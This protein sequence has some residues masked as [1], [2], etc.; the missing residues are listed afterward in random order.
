MQKRWIIREAPSQDI[1]RIAGEHKISPLLSQILLQRKLVTSEE[2]N[3]FL[4]PTLAHLPDPD[5]MHGM[6]KATER[7]IY[8]L[9]N[10]EQITIYGDY[11]VD[12]T[13]S[14]VLLLDFLE[15]LGAKVDFYI[16]H[17]MKEGYSLNEEAMRTLAKRGT[18]LL[19]TVD[20]GI[21]AVHEAKLIKKLG[22][23]LIITDHH[24]VPA[25]L[26]EAVAILNPKQADCKFSGKELAGV[27]VAFYLIIALRRALREANLLPDQEPN[28]RQALDL[29]AVGTIADM[30]PLTGVNRILVREGLKVLSQK[31]RPGFAALLEI[32][33]VEESVRSDQVAF[34]IGP[35]INAVGRLDEASLGVR[36]LRTRHEKEAREMAELLDDANISRKELEDDIVQAAIALIEKEGLL[37]S[38]RSLVV[39]GE[40]WHQGVIGI[41]ASRLVER[42]YRPA[43]VLTRD[44]NGLKG[45]ARSIRG[46]HLVEALGQC[47]EYLGKFGGHAYAAGLSMPQKN[48][49]AF[50]KSF[51]QIVRTK[52]N[53]EDFQPSL[54]LDGVSQLQ[55]IHPQFLEELSLLEPFGLG[56]PQ[57]LFL[58]KQA[59]VR[60]SRIVGENHLRMR[61]GPKDKAQGH[62]MGA[63]GFRLAEKQPEAHTCV[64]LACV[65]E[66][67][68]WNGMKNI[69]LRLV[70][71]RET[72]NVA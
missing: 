17:R 21:S 24:E 68:E 15:A 31:N 22:M 34:R 25:V 38:H 43:I 42:F 72:S 16:P 64:D 1:A 29:V 37:Y 70:D 52:L 32:A 46:F 50:R 8:A 39:Y 45:S 13:T 62:S 27:G 11:D 7:L 44:Q 40:D 19:I 71:L 55:E 2:I 54:K 4:H 47:R 49:E 63:I 69:Q 48:L 33:G 35:R 26:P 61:V 30:A 3:Q 28:L 12:G 14:T 9:K 36:L 60:E 57:P 41:V 65:P 18:Q 5:L 53:E 66:W 56:N 23:D 10:K 51:D 6:R 59:M 20:N 67:N 58:L